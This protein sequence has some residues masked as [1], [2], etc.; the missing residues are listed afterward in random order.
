MTFR[1]NAA[2]EMMRNPEERQ[3]R[4]LGILEFKI[5]DPLIAVESSSVKRNI[6]FVLPTNMNLASPRLFSPSSVAATDLFHFC[7]QCVGG[8]KTAAHRKSRRR[9]TADESCTQ[10][11]AAE[12][13]LL[14]HPALTFWQC[15]LPD[16][17]NS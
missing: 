1:K 11:D 4:A 16:R 9:K 7:L 3:S 10:V 8:C 14:P 13:T 5:T 15:D 6:F 17:R 12:E 2:D